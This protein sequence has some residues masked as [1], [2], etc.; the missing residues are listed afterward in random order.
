M[1]KLNKLGY[2]AA[3]SISGLLF[4]CGGSDETTTGIQNI[5][6]NTETGEISFDE[7]EGAEYY[8]ASVSRVINATTGE[9]LESAKQ[10]SQITMSDKTTKWIWNTAT[11]SNAYIEKEDEESTTVSASIVY[12]TFSSSASSAGTTMSASEIG[13]GH[14]IITL[15][16]FDDNDVASEPTYYEFVKEGSLNE[17]KA[18][19][20][21]VNSD[22]HIEINVASGYYLDAFTVSGLPE[23]LEFNV[24]DSSGTTVETIKEE[25]FSYTNVVVGP[26]KSYNFNNE[27][28]TGTATLNSSETYTVDITAK[29]DGDKVLDATGTTNDGATNPYSSSN[30]NNNGGVPNGGGDNPGGGD[31][32][33]SGSGNSIYPSCPFVVDLTLDTFTATLTGWQDKE[34]T[35]TKGTPASDDVSYVY[36]IVDDTAYKATMTLYADG[37]VTYYEEASGPFAEITYNGTYTVDGT[38][39][40][41]NLDIENGSSSGDNSGGDTNQG[42]GDNQGTTDTNWV[43]APEDI[44]IDEGAESFTYPLGTSET[45]SGMLATKSATAT[46]GSDYTYTL[47]NTDSAPFTVSGTLELVT[48]GTAT[49]AVEAVG[50]ISATSLTGTWTTTDSKITISF[51]N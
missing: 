48:G 43:V 9:A 38:T 44:T 23:Y 12:R 20:S 3:L 21:S 27:T 47:A 42:G 8:S 40:T 13:V 10:A 1:K 25:D 39:A 2:I 34:C 7:V 6:Y 4:A 29:G 41:I 30:N 16:S 5:S 36:S 31:N 33:N 50:P 22:N 46:S 26:S 14:Y 19:T 18:F 35:F 49:L 24:K 17:I 45:L 51:G 37:T 15:Y 28:I 11:G 32:N